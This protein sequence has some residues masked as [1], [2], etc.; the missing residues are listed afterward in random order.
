[1]DIQKKPVILAVDDNP[2]N[3]Q[4]LG[5]ILEPAGY[6]VVLAISA[7]Q[8][9]DYLKN[10]K[11]N[12]I[13]LDVMMPE[14]DGFELCRRIKSIPTVKDIPVI[15]LTAKTSTED[16]VRGFE[17]GAVDYVPK[18]FNQ[19]ELNARV[20]THLE[21]KAQKDEIIRI[22]YEREVL[23]R[24]FFH[25]IMNLAGGIQ[26]V[27]SVLNNRTNGQTKELIEMIMTASDLLIDEV[28]AQK[29][30]R[31]AENGELPLNIE[32]VNSCCILTDL[33]KIYKNHEVAERK[34]ITVKC[35][36]PAQI[37]CDRAILT[38]IIGNMMK[39]ALE[40]TSPGGEI[41]TG[42]I[43]HHDTGEV[44]FF[45][46]NPSCIPQ[47]IQGRIFQRSFSTK[48]KGRGLGT[49]SMKLLGEKYLKGTVGFTTDATSDTTFFIKLKQAEN[50]D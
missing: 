36:E 24:I 6:A 11:P 45:V 23:E 43:V 27:A 22:S 25:D 1:M 17:A 26:G 35:S 16:I 12:L 9:L 20:K 4:V 13:L 49:Y 8:A 33:M 10:E 5:N 19:A 7:S 21:L 48:D 3:L 39:N 34:T 50:I 44:E 40:A 28:K 30:L 31:L 2:Q 38:R 42:C 47:D 15:F 41:K 46:N 37:K 29:Q 18:P 32:T 14:M